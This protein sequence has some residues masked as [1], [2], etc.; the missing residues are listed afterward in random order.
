LFKN[1]PEKHLPFVGW[2]FKRIQPKASKPS[3]SSVFDED[4]SSDAT[5]ESSE[6]PRARYED[7]SEESTSE[8]DRSPSVVTYNDKMQ[9]S[10]PAALLSAPPN[11][12]KRNTNTLE[13]S[14]DSPG[15]R[16][17]APKKKDKRK[18]EKDLLS[19]AEPDEKKKKR[20]SVKQ[21]PL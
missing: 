20:T 15:R 18:S 6:G 5:M 8:H 12:T 4:P 16:D 1:L 10:N 9:S 14:V 19:E 13:E 2:T 21:N 17:S 11:S 3:A 7:A